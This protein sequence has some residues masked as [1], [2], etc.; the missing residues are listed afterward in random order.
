MSEED[1]ILIID[2]Q[3]V[4]AKGQKWACQNF[5][6]TVSNIQ[7]IIKHIECTR[8]A[9]EMDASDKPPAVLLT[10]F[11]APENPAGTWKVYNQEN[12]D[13]NESSWL[14]ELIPDMKSLEEKYPVYTKSTYSSLSIEQVRNAATSARDRGGCVVLTGVLA[15]CCVLWTA[16]DAIDLG[17]R[18][19]YLT[20]GISGLNKDKQAAVE[21]ILS[22]LDPMQIRL[23][24]TREYL[25]TISFPIVQT[26]VQAV[27][28]F[29]HH[30]PDLDPVYS[31]N[32]SR[33]L[34]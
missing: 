19:I 12:Q 15:E 6:R 7:S 9:H 32:M 30:S 8:T 21:H 33:R 24:K 1:L 16:C 25:G 34:P 4:Y 11:I 18:T 27:Q 5:Q 10:K 3:N 28:N 14:N 23:M 26:E 2:M 20:D 29:K 13:V 31:G 22:G 17:C